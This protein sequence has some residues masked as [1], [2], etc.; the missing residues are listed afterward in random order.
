MGV[1]WGSK[2][3]LTKEVEMN[4]NIPSSIKKEILMIERGKKLVKKEKVYSREK[5]LIEAIE[6]LRF[7]NEVANTEPLHS[8]LK[9][10]AIRIIPFEPYFPDSNRAPLGG[11]WLETKRGKTRLFYWLDADYPVNRSDEDHKF[12]GED[13]LADWDPSSLQQFAGLTKRQVWRN[14]REWL[15]AIR[16][17][18]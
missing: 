4:I 18:L 15:R 5:A 7:L 6:N 10:H 11:L 9:K 1:W 14:I 3:R 8:F 12:I 16:S 17:N 13:R 2:K